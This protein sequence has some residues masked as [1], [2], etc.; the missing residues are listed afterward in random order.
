MQK[1]PVCLMDVNDDSAF[2]MEYNGKA[3]YFCTKFCLEKFKKN[4]ENYLQ[5]HKD[6]LD[7]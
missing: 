6:M 4:P 2:Q 3:Y 7:K 1:D 5:R